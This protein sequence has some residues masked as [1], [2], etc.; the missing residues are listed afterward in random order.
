MRAIVAALL[1]LASPAAAQPAPAGEQPAIP[2]DALVPNEQARTLFEVLPSNVMTDEMVAAMFEAVP[3]GDTRPVDDV[4]EQVLARGERVTGW[5][6]SGI[7][8]LPV[9]AARDGGLAG[10]MAE[11]AS[12]FGPMLSYFV[13]RP[14]E[15]LVRPEWVLVA[16]RGAPFSDDNVQVAIG[17]ISPKVILAERIAY[18]RQGNAYCQARAES[19]LYADPAIGASEADMIVLLMTMRSLW[20]IQQRGMCEVVEETGPGQYR[21]RLFDPE[22]HRLSAA[23]GQETFRIVPRRAFPARAEPR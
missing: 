3:G 1:L 18:R 15:R 9:I 12:Q 17:Y 20:M 7:D 11:G 14:I 2:A 4:I 22:G 19:R 23:E 16:R 6:E 5:Q 10:N 21:T 8:L 13:D